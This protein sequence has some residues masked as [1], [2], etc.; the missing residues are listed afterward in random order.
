MTQRNAHDEILAWCRSN[1]PGTGTP[2]M[3]L[4][5]ADGASCLVVDVTTTE[6]YPNPHYPGHRRS[7]RLA[8]GPTWEAVAEILGVEYRD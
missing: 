3:R 4:G 2:C 7:R 8:A 1:P 6:E 5:T